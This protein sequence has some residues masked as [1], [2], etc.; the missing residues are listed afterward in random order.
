MPQVTKMY[1][2]Q[3]LLKDI[4]RAIPKTYL[5]EKN[6]SKMRQTTLKTF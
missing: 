2:T 5:D 4:L 6:M 3:K 1:N